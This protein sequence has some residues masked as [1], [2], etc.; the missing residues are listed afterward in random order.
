MLVLPPSTAQLLRERKTASVT[1]WI[2]FNPVRPEQPANLSAQ[3]YE[4]PAKAGGAAQHPLPRPPHTFATNALEH[5]LDIKPLST[6]I[7]HV[8][9]ATTLNVYAYV[10]DDMKK[11]AAMKIDQGIAGQS[12]KWHP[13]RGPQNHPDNLPSQKGQIPQTGDGLYQPNQRPFMG[14]RLLFKGQREAGDP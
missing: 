8:P 4:S 6:I 3:P 5:G 9:S 10:T 13:Q 11:T 2:F 1:E 14:E 12:R 7:G